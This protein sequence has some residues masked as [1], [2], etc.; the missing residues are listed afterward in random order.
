[1]HV[2][3]PAGTTGEVKLIAPLTLEAIGATVLAAGLT[4]EDELAHTLATL[5]TQAADPTHITSLPR[6]IQSW[7]HRSGPQPS[8]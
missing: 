4:T 6:I 3:Q 2:V 1:M 7:A 5:H 8:P